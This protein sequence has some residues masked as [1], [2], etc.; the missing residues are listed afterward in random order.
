MSLAY[1][2]YT[3]SSIPKKCENSLRFYEPAAALGMYVPKAHRGFHIV[4]HCLMLLTKVVSL[5]P[6]FF[7]VWLIAVGKYCR[8]CLGLLA[9]MT[10]HYNGVGQSILFVCLFWFFLGGVVSCF[11]AIT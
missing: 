1:R 8:S 9:L 6:N 4:R 3:G 11:P 10:A 5:Y 2:Y 7:E